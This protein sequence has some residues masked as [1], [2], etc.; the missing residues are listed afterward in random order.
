MNRK[1]FQTI[2]RGEGRMARKPFKVLSSVALSA[3]L[4]TALVPGIVIH[5]DDVIAKA[6]TNVVVEIE[7]Q[8]VSIDV[9]TFNNLKAVQK[10]T[11]QDVLYVIANDGNIYPIDLFYAAKAVVGGDGSSAETLAYLAEDAGNSVAINIVEGEVDNEGNLS[12]G[13]PVEPADPA[14]DVVHDIPAIPVVFGTDIA[15]I[16]LPETVTAQLNDEDNTEVTLEIEWNEDE[17]ASYDKHKA[18]TYAIT[19][20]ARVDENADY[21]IS[22]EVAVVTV[23]I[24]VEEPSASQ[25][26]EAVLAVNA[27][28]EAAIF[29]PELLKEALKSPYLNLSNINEDYIHDYKAEII[30]SV[31]NTK[32]RIQSAIN[33]VNV[34]KQDEL[35]GQID[36]VNEASSFSGL[37]TALNNLGI[38]NVEVSSAFDQAYFDAID[39]N[40]TETKG[41]I[42]AIIDQTNLTEITALVVEAEEQLTQAAHDEV[43]LAML[44]LLDEA[45][46]DALKERLAHVQG[47]VTVNGATDNAELATGLQGLENIEAIENYNSMNDQAYWASFNQLT[48]GFATVE[49]IQA[50]IDQVNA[51]ELASAVDGLIADVNQ[52]LNMNQLGN[53]LQALA[54]DELIEHYRSSNNS[55][56]WTAFDL[57][58][59]S[60]TTV[61]EI[62][63]FV[64]TVNTEEALIE[65]NGITYNDNWDDIYN[66]LVDEVLN[67]E[68]VF[69]KN[70]PLYALVIEEE[71]PFEAVDAVQS[72]IDAVNNTTLGKLNTATKASE[73]RGL[74]QVLKQEEDLDLELYEE[75]TNAQ[76]T[77]LETIIVHDIQGFDSIEVLQF[78]IL[79]TSLII[80]TNNI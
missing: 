7:G 48:E 56:Y 61:E 78:F 20:A 34:D 1:D 58:T 71:A 39:S 33:R 66:K 49:E 14:V 13:G 23:S 76:K 22:E 62:Q 67:L 75:L 26:S 47:L 51:D 74:L 17:L 25:V 16:N 63:T 30:T 12:P 15:D 45:D 4:S 37:K 59:E 5:A 9:D 46:K 35:Q 29:D 18:G 27:A 38:Q 80:L 40:P 24:I 57:M 54:A 52:S 65:V 41:Q 2:E 31:T 10:I 44:N 11:G 6:L 69:K 3:V 50:F 42:Q 32:S 36:A 68:K 43:T 28:A 70:I 77:I 8:F 79:E 55:A 53:A 73:V 21:T 64:N 60:F 19:G 72:I